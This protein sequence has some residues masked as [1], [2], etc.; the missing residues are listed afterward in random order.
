MKSV[1]ENVVDR[2][3][4]LGKLPP[5][6]RERC[7]DEVHEMIKPDHIPGGGTVSTATNLRTA[8]P[9]YRCGVPTG[10]DIQS[11]PFFCG[12]PATLIADAEKGCA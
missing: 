2:L 8:P 11:G 6:H 12:D 3:I 1:A 4:D 5:G 7:V 10:E 9:G